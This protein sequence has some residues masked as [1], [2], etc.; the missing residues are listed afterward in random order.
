MG[1]VGDTG[2][3]RFVV[4]LYYLSERAS[5]VSGIVSGSPVLRKRS[6]SLTSVVVQKNALRSNSCFFNNS[7][8]E[9]VA[10]AT[11][12]RLF[13]FFFVCD[14]RQIA[15]CRVDVVLAL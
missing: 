8:N 3:R 9:C 6:I 12:L 15:T 5:T 14:W 7:P 2:E 1:E 11:R 10:V 13:P 4:F